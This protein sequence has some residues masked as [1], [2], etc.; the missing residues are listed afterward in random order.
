MDILEAD[1]DAYLPKEKM[2]KAKAHYLSRGLA[3]VKI[4]PGSNLKNPDYEV[5]QVSWY[6]DF[7]PL[8]LYRIRPIDLDVKADTHSMTEGGYFRVSSTLALK[9]L[10]SYSF[11]ESLYYWSRSREHAIAQKV[12][13]LSADHIPSLHEYCNTYL[14]NPKYL[15]SFNSQRGLELIYLHCK[16]LS[17]WNPIGVEKTKTFWGKSKN[18]YYKRAQISPQACIPGPSY[19]EDSAF[20]LEGKFHQN[21]KKY[22]ESYEK[23]ESKKGF[24]TLI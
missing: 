17:I 4:L 11:S 18:V 8:Y 21:S 7:D 12:P 9:A 1:W 2:P 10:D 6:S 13:F 3:E 19:T 14:E 5:S 15:E 23:R 22:C 20:L 16:N 24:L